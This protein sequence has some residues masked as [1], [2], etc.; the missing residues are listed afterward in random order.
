V[1]CNRLELDVK[2]KIE[3][4][5][6]G[7]RKK[8]GIVCAMQHKPKLYI[9][10]E[11]TSGLDPLMQK[12]FWNI[13]KERNQEG[14]TIFLSSHVLSEVQ[15]HCKNA[16]IIRGGKLIVS[17]S[18]SALSKTSARRVNLHGIN[19]VCGL[20]GVRD[21]VNH[22]DSVSF[23]YQGDIKNLVSYIN[24]LNITDMTITEP[25]LE[26]MFMHYYEKDGE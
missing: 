4:L 14:A 1:L 8:V 7:N 11:P 25:D 24:N 13:L 15:R 5:S 9:L 12:E 18:V 20:E 6:L 19:D 21:V 17:D 23:L 26:E 22:G 3:D 10:D 16:G 2:K